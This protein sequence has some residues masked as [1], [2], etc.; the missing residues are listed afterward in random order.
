M[1]E[2][3]VFTCRPPP[4]DADTDPGRREKTLES[5]EIAF[6]R[7]VFTCRRHSEAPRAPQ[8][9]RGCPRMPPQKVPGGRFIRVFTP[10]RRFTRDFTCRRGPRRA[11][12]ADSC[13][14]YVFSLR[15]AEAQGWSRR[16]IHMCVYNVFLACVPHHTCF[17]V[18]AVVG[19]RAGVV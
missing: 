17:Y 5:Y 15:V 7:R 16:P 14:F 9:A 18:S 19:R 2:G 1:R 6:G 11:Q 12:E 4:G 13:V 10:G 3:R 8:E